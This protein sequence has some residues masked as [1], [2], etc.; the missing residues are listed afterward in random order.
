MSSKMGVEVGHGQRATSRENRTSRQGERSSNR[1]GDH[2]VS[3][4]G[5]WYVLN[6]VVV[7]GMNVGQIS[8]DAPARV[9]L[10]MVLYHRV[11]ASECLVVLR[12][13]SCSLCT[14]TRSTALSRLLRHRVRGERRPCSGDGF[15]RRLSSSGIHSRDTQRDPTTNHSHLHLDE[16]MLTD[17]NDMV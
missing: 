12:T 3:N 2:E 10:C 7:R 11:H 4:L 6:K 16:G 5:D 17:K 1:S 13:S 14:G 15:L 9:S 8:R